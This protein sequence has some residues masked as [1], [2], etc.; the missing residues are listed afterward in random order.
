MLKGKSALITGSLDGI[1]FAIA[2]AL[3]RNGCAVMLNGFGDAETIKARVATLRELGAKADYHGCDLSVPEQITDMVETT[4]GKFGAIDIVVNNAVTRHYAP[5]EELPV[6][7]WNY[8]LAVNLSAPFHII[9]QVMPA[10]KARKWGRIVSL[11]SNYALSGTTQR[12]DYCSTKHGIVGL[13]KVVALEGLPYGITANVICPGATYTS[14]SKAKIAERMAASG[15]SE[16]EATR[17]Y[18]ETRQPSRRFVPASKI[19]DLV[20]FLC[21]DAA[22]EMTGTPITMDGGWMAFS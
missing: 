18:L 13:T 4:S 3:A 20:V 7:A 12:T 22:S 2:Q 1:G 21:S 15:K 14:I 5:I 9:R 8:A 11:G 17:D 19:G 6:E 10:M 16:E